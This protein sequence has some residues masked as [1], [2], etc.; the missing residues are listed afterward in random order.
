M[1]TCVLNLPGLQVKL[2]LVV[3]QPLKAVWVLFSPM[4]SRR[5]DGCQAELIGQ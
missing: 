5:T 3:P 2:H 1:F 4:A